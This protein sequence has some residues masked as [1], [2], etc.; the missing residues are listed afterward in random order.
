MEDTQRLG[1]AIAKATV[2]IS[3]LGPGPK[4]PA[5]GE[6]PFAAYYSAMFPLMCSSSSAK[7]ILVMG[8]AAIHEKDDRGSFVASLMTSVVR[9]AFP[10]GYRTI[11]D[12][13]Q[14]FQKKAQGLDWT[15]LRLSMVQGGGDALS[16]EKDRQDATFA[17]S[18]GV[19]GWTYYIKRGGLAKWLVDQ[20][21]QDGSGAP[22]SVPA[23][24]YTRA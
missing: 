1:T 6:F 17:G 16:W 21:E 7:R 8:T 19:K 20:A 12:I 15:I 13:H 2:I 4:V 24:S 22:G 9:F 18:L 10:A 14:A 3:L 11:L 5:S 23:V